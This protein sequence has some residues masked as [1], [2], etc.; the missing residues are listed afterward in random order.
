M[1]RCDEHTHIVSISSRH[2]S[3]SLITSALQYKDDEE[4]VLW[5]NTVGPYQNRQETYAYFSL[6]F[7]KGSKTI[8]NH[9]H[10]SLSE[11]LQGVELEFSG[12]EI[13]YKTEVPVETICKTSLTPDKLKAFVYAIR[14]DYWYQMYIDDLPIWGK[15]SSTLSQ[16]CPGYQS[17][18]SRWASGTATTTT[19]TRTSGSRSA[20]TASAL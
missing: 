18:D 14:N 15:V 11:A 17:S 20:T 8:I 9:Y 13:F 10:E 16:L 1:G 19:S 2:S 3:Q 12:Y 7:C 5:M 6:P 4:V